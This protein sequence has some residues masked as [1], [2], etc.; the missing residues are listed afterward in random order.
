LV[1]YAAPCDSQ[2]VAPIATVLPLIVHDVGGSLIVIV[3][4][5]RLQLRKVFVAEMICVLELLVALVQVQILPAGQT[6]GTGQRSP[7]T[8]VF[9]TF[10]QKQVVLPFGHAAPANKVNCAGHEDPLLIAFP[11]SEHLHPY[12]KLQ[13]DP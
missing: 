6:A 3:S 4:L 7:P 12:W 8:I 11:V 13:S 5:T 2:A 1:S 10:V 9:E